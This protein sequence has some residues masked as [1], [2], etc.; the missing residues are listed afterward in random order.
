MKVFHLLL[1]LC[2]FFALNCKTSKAIFKCVLNKSSDAALAFFVNTFKISQ[3]M[4]YGLLDSNKQN[5][6][7]LINS[8]K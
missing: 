4:A 7:D 5:V 3:S 1:I 8:C 2:L 6:I